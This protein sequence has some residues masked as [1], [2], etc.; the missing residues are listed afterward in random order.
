[1]GNSASVLEGDNNVVDVPD[2]SE[3]LNNSN[4]NNCNYTIILN[5]VSLF[6]SI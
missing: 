6:K 4:Y 2:I 5:H 1:M 3:K